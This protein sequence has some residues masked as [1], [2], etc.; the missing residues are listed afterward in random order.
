VQS[1]ARVWILEFG[2]RAWISCIVEWSDGGLDSACH[3]SPLTFYFYESDRAIDFPASVRRLE[4]SWTPH[5][6]SLGQVGRS[7]CG[8]ISL[9]LD[10]YRIDSSMV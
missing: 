9:R 4:L 5:F 7:N 8:D 6:A 10:D 2:D 1:W 3:N